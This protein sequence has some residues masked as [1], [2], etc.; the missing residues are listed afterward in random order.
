MENNPYIQNFYEHEA[1]YIKEYDQVTDQITSGFIKEAY[2]CHFLNPEDKIEAKPSLLPLILSYFGVLKGRLYDYVK[3]QVIDYFSKPYVIRSYIEILVNLCNLQIGQDAVLSREMVM[4]S[5]KRTGFIQD[6]SYDEKT[7]TY[8]MISNQG[9]QM[10]FHRLFKSAAM[11]AQTANDC[12]NASL[13]CIKEFTQAHEK[14]IGV[15]VEETFLT[16]FPIYHSF[17]IYYGM[18]L[19]G[20]RNIM[21][22]FE[23]YQD[24]IQPTIISFTQGDEML[25]EI[26]QLQKTDSMFVKSNYPEMLNY[27]MHKQMIKEKRKY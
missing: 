12:H 25:Q 22:Q 26:S 10:A 16:N 21:M 1:K 20:G 5:F 3:T 18:M 15:T 2:A 23:D 4:K 8:T 17:A 24:L 7:D 13:S 19:D 6:I 11:R 27:A 14:I 9:K